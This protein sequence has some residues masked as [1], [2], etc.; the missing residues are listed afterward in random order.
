MDSLFIMLFSLFLRIKK[1]VKF[2]LKSITTAAKT[3]T[4]TIASSPNL[5]K[6]DTEI[7]GKEKFLMIIP[8][9]GRVSKR[10]RERE[11]ERNQVQQLILD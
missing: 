1:N 2:S 6:S 7:T 11:Q 3:I 9:R 8:K 10:E 4:T 5:A